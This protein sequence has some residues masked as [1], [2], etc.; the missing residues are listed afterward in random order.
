M[1]SSIQGSLLPCKRLV[2]GTMTGTSLDGIDVTLSQITGIGLEMKV[3]VLCHH[4]EAFDESLKSQ[5]TAFANQEPMRARDITALSYTF[6]L[7]HLHAIEELLQI[8]SRS[9]SYCNR[10]IDLIAVH[11]QTVFHDPPLSWQ[12]FNPSPV[13][14]KLQIP[15]VFD[16]RAA[17]LA[18]GG[19][20]APIT[21]LADWIIFRD[22][23]C[24]ESRAVVNLGG[25]CNITFISAIAGGDDPS[26]SITGGDVCACNQLLDMIARDCLGKEYD[27][28]GEYACSGEALDEVATALE[29]QL[30]CQLFDK[31]SLGTADAPVDWLSRHVH[32]AGNDLARSACK[33]IAL[34]ITKS[35]FGNVHVVILAGGGALN[36]A[37][38]L[39]LKRLNPGVQVVLSSAFGIDPSYREAVEMSVLG[40]LCQDKVPITLSAITGCTPPIAGIWCYPTRLEKFAKHARHEGMKNTEKLIYDEGMPMD[41]SHVLTEQRNPRSMNLHKLSIAACLDLIQ[42]E[43]EYVLHAMKQALGEILDFVTAAEPGFLAG[44]RL[45]Y[46]GAGSSG[47]IGVLDASEAPPTFHVHPGRVVGIIAGGDRALRLSSEGA[48]DDL[49]GAIAELDALGITCNDTV[50]GIAAGGST[51]Y[52]LGALDYLVT[53]LPVDRRPLTGLLTCTDVPL[54]VRTVV[55]HVIVLA[56]GPEIVTG[57]TRMKAG[58]ATKLVLN[59]ISTTLMVR[60]GKVY[61]NLMVDVKA[62]NSKLKDRAGRIVMEIT[63][64]SRVEAF[65]LLERAAGCCK[66][67]VVMWKMEIKKEEA[68][69]LLDI[70]NGR[71][72]ELIPA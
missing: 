22:R 51:P 19:Q 48:E 57:S 41:R 17:D 33:A 60:L 45:V 7:C 32:V 31:K 49:H 56:V 28:N 66:V 26:Q 24:K 55:P 20:G 52:V 43:D 37:L 1:A 23:T 4:S 5:L 54:H 47:R 71:L 8:F 27:A 40:V 69:K 13:V 34:T 64:L 68:E 38:V 72:A 14:H 67:A 50:L 30:T 15:I 35:F 39:E 53:C 16:M 58:T 2:I 9:T 11:G 59:S 36:K 21:P 6:A 3:E 65:Q 42:N 18:S 29:T 12:L 70:A 63:G 61:E 10:P 25:F 46:L 62:S 44:G